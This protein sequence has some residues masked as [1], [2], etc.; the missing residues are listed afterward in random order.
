MPRWLAQL[1]QLR[2]K[3]LEHRDKKLGEKALH[4]YAEKID[5][6]PATLAIG[7]LE[8]GQVEKLFDLCCVYDDQELNSV[9]PRPLPLTLSEFP[10]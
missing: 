6:K 8:L 1:K 5:T 4:D 9:P 3:V 7:T 10:Y 2:D